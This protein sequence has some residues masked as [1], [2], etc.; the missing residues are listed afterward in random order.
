MKAQGRVLAIYSIVVLDWGRGTME[1]L[2][3]EIFCGQFFFMLYGQLL[4]QTDLTNCGK[5]ASKILD[6][7]SEER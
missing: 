1:C 6:I 5:E 3:H 2:R 7:Q 4:T